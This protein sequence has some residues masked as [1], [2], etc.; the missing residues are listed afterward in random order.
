M[1]KLRFIS[2]V[3]LIAVTAFAVN[4]TREHTNS[5]SQTIDTA[6]EYFVLENERD[7]LALESSVQERG[8]KQDEL[9]MIENLSDILNL[10]NNNLNSL[11]AAVLDFE[12]TYGSTGSP[13]QTQERIAMIRTLANQKDSDQYMALNRQFLNRH[14]ISIAKRNVGAS[15]FSFDGFETVKL[16]SNIKNAKPGQDVA[17]V[18]NN[19]DHASGGSFSDISIKQDGQDIEKSV[20]RLENMAIVNFT[21]SGNGKLQ[22]AF[23]SSV[24]IGDSAVAKQMALDLN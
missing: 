14:V 8:N 5:E 17:V 12:K 9:R 7:F 16:T 3:S 11:Q 2:F 18:L 13:K 10:P 21:P 24:P 15:D 6:L 23:K 20:T 22:I 4:C 1:K 19:L